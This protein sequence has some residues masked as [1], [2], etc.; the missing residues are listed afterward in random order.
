MSVSTS[1]SAA[2]CALGA[3][4]ASSRVTVRPPLLKP[5]EIC[6]RV[7]GEGGVRTVSMRLG[8][9]GAGERRQGGARGR[10]RGRR[11]A[12]AGRRRETPPWRTLAP[13]AQ[14]AQAVGKGTTGG[15]QLHVAAAFRPLPLGVARR[16]S[17]AQ[18][19]AGAARLRD[20]LAHARGHLLVARRAPERVGQLRL[21][22]DERGQ[23]LVD[24]HLRRRR[25][26]V[27]AGGWVRAGFRG[28]S[29][30]QRWHATRSTRLCMRRGKQ[31]DE[32]VKERR[33]PH[34]HADRPAVVLARAVH[35]DEDPLVGV[36][37]EAVACGESRGGEVRL[38][39]FVRQSEE[40]MMARKNVMCRR[41]PRTG[42]SG[43]RY[44]RH[45]KARAPRAGRAAAF[46]RRAAARTVGSERRAHLSGGRTARRRG[47]APWPLPA[48]HR[49]R[50]QASARAR[51]PRGAGGRCCSEPP[52]SCS[53]TR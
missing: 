10:P 42:R 37:R 19:G 9:R 39:S 7:R 48:G 4:S 44:E 24:A 30:A 51:E 40:A 34:R 41:I 43:S 1:A 23:L 18:Q 52:C 11:R 28:P 53:G 8:Q 45:P 29:E 22:A 38:L 21:G 20:G 46:A 13:G 2:F 32:D 14:S 47:A 5:R 36:R 25:D 49:A 33:K 35:V 27:R 3:T 26:G 31:R 16:G 17:A 12:P 15:P 50:A 6:G